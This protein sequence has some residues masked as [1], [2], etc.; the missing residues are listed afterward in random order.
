MAGQ[1]EHTDLAHA[2]DAASES[3]VL[4]YL[5]IK[6]NWMDGKNVRDFLEWFETWREEQKRWG[7][8]SAQIFA[9]WFGGTHHL[10]CIYGLRSI[11]RWNAGV[12]S[13]SGL[14]AIFSVCEILNPKS[15][16]FEI[17]KKIPVE[18]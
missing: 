16:C 18:F 2:P 3:P 8:V 1:D 12:D 11:D 15:L 14:D 9:G 7:V 6:G 10:T 13:A 5:I 17:V 4:Y